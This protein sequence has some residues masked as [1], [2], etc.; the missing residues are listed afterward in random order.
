MKAGFE[1]AT[2]KIWF[3]NQATSRKIENVIEIEHV[4]DIMTVKT[5]DDNILLINFNNVNLVEEL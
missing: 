2:I 3:A 1:K 4:S 5:A